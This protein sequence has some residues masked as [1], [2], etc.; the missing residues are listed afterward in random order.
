MVKI[1]MLCLEKQC[2]KSFSWNCFSRVEF[3]F[4]TLFIDGSHWSRKLELFLLLFYYLSRCQNWLWLQSNGRDKIEISLPTV[5]VL[6]GWRDSILVKNW[7]WVT[8]WLPRLVPREDL[9]LGHIERSSS[10]G[11]KKFRIY[12]LLSIFSVVPSFFGLWSE[13]G[14]NLTRSSVVTNYRSFA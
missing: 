4:F 8:L 14:W 13:W 9:N 12:H 5:Y 6:C 10:N 11:W 1:S 3:R 7:I 2:F